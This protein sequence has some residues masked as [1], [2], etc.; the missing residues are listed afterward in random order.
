MVISFEKFKEIVGVPEATGEADDAVQA[1]TESS[2]GG[3]Y[4]QFGEEQLDPSPPAEKSLFLAD[5]I[6]ELVEVEKSRGGTTSR[7]LEPDGT[8]LDDVFPD[9]FT[10]YETDVGYHIIVV[11]FG[12]VHLSQIRKIP[13]FKNSQYDQ[14]DDILNRFAQYVL[15][16]YSN[17]QTLC[18]IAARDDITPGEEYDGDFPYAITFASK[19]KGDVEEEESL[20][21]FF[22]EQ[23]ALDWE[24]SLRDARLRQFYRSRIVEEKENGRRINRWR[25]AASRWQVGLFLTPEQWETAKSLISSVEETEVIERIEGR[26]VETLNQAALRFGFARDENSK[27]R[28]QAERLESSHPL[29]VKERDWAKQGFENDFLANVVRDNNKELVGYLLYF[30]GGE[31]EDVQKLRDRL[32]SSNIFQNVL[33]LYCT[34]EEGFGVEVWDEDQKIKGKLLSSAIRQSKVARLLSII[35]RFFRVSEKRL[36]TPRVLARSLAKRA[37]YLKVFALQEMTSDRGGK[38]RKLQESFRNELIADLSRNDFADAYA[39]SLT[40]GLLTSRILQAADGRSASNTPFTVDSAVNSIGLTEFLRTFFQEI[41]EAARDTKLEWLL[42]EM[43]ELLYRANIP[44]AFG[45]HGEQADVRDPIVEFYEPFLN[46]DDRDAQMERGVF[47]TPSP[48]VEYMNQLVDHV[49]RER[50]SVVDGLGSV[51]ETVVMNGDETKLKVMDLGVGSGTF[52]VRLLERYVLPRLSTKEEKESA[53]QLDV[54]EILESLIGFEILLA[55]YII[56]H[57]RILLSFRKAGFNIGDESRASIYLTNSLDVHPEQG[58]QPTLGFEFVS[59]EA[60]RA[61]RLKEDVKPSVIV[62]N[63][64]YSQRTADE[65]IRQFVIPFA[66]P[67]NNYDSQGKM[68]RYSGVRSESVVPRDDRNSGKLSD[69]YGFFM[70]AAMQMIDEPGVICLITSN[71]YLSIPT[72]KFFRKF[73]LDNFNIEFLINFNNISERNSVFAP[74]A[75]IATSIIVLSGPKSKNNVVSILDLAGVEEISKKYE[76]ICKVDW[77]GDGVDRT[78][79]RGFELKPLKECDF[80]EVPQERFYDH[81][82]YMFRVSEFEL[83]CRKYQSASVKLSELAR[84]FQGVDVGDVTNL[85]GDTRGELRNKIESYVLDG[86]LEA[87]TKTA[88]RGIKKAQKKG[89]IDGEFVEEKVFPFAFQKNMCRWG[90]GETSYVYMDHGVLWRSRMRTRGGK[91]KT[92]VFCDEKLFVLERREQNRL[93]SLVTTEAIVPQHGGRFFYL[94]AGDVLSRGDLYVLSAVLN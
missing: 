45:D 52:L 53:S 38:L 34:G 72:Y 6:R 59:E 88:R 25:G 24:S 91:P 85:V 80:S 2:D 78:D 13:L 30:V 94:V 42:D 60:R 56:A 44:Y 17:D 43:A 5:L 50:F 9:E 12:D 89:G 62:G 73:V 54:E 29:G 93:V 90:L 55:P 61:D 18:I 39:Q 7:S 83:I 26:A 77:K 48:I 57:L 65:S 1:G 82:G 67:E 75:G 23:R 11:D 3:S 36:K 71:T 51:G 22:F 35:D 16:N 76:A 46:E 63:P 69:V 70:G 49:L 37:R 31:R 47:Y 92:E 28:I 68:V 84:T 74:D 40:Y 4:K 21:S 33:V 8:T 79:I 32:S 58:G 10:I 14:I 15:S 19:W 81:P 87:L 27:Q 64:P 86:H 66:Y 41:F 20:V